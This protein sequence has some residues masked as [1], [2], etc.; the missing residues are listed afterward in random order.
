MCKKCIT[1]A[2]AI[3]LGLIVPNITIAGEV[4]VYGRAHISVD[5]LNNGTESSLYFSNN[6]SR[7]G[8]KASQDL[9][10]DIKG[11]VQFE[12]GYD[13]TDN[14]PISSNRDNYLALSGGFGKIKLGRLSSPGKNHM[15]R[16][17]MFGDQIGDA[18]NLLG[19]Q[20]DGR[21]NM[22]Q[23]SIPTMNGVNANACIVPEEG[24]KDSGALFACADYSDGAIF[25]G[26]AYSSFGKAA[27]TGTESQSTIQVLASYKLLDDTLRLMSVYQTTT[28]LGGDSAKKL[29]VIGAGAAFNITPET[30]IKG[31]FYKSGNTKTDAKDGATMIAVGIDHTLSDTTTAY[32]AYASTTN[33]ENATKT[34]LYWGHGESPSVDAGKDPSGI[35][36][37]V[38]CKF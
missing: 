22:V 7:L 19:G 6:A 2:I 3:L 29:K 18:G 27:N 36:A 21:Y 15:D 37:G 32:L 33:E 9:S 13:P 34:P 11:E 20:G 8:F 17:Q 14:K 1:V 35:S 23:Y 26:V 24:K 25:A 28:N 4:T 31:H 10:Y 5:S 30:T 12:V 38:V 16:N